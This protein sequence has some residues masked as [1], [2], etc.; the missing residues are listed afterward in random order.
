M[1]RYTTECI[2]TFFLVLIIALTVTQGMEEAPL[3][4]GAGLAALV[5]MGGPISG[6]HYNPAVTLGMWL[7][8]W[9]EAADVLPYVLAQLLGAGAAALAAT[10][11]TGAVYAPSPGPEVTTGAALTAEVFFTF[12][13]MLV[14]LSVATSAKTQGNAY[15]GVAIGLTVTAGAY[16]VGTT[17]GGVFNPAVGTGPIMT[18][19]LSGGT[20]TNVWL[21]WVGPVAGALVAVPVFKIQ[22]SS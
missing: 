12:A 6:A 10:Q 1:A 19:L 15:Y 22:D 17:S 18:S 14:I 3:A 7:R 5:Y 2:G 9:L 16:A 11:L 20:A 21:Y 8:G 13:L 4:I